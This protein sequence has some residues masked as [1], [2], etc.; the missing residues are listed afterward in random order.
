MK[1]LGILFLLLNDFDSL[2]AINWT[3]YVG[4]GTIHY[5]FTDRTQES[6]SYV[7]MKRIGFILKMRIHSLRA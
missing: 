6:K 4:L 7:I 3:I 2:S 1:C 5:G